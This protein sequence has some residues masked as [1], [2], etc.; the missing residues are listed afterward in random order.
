MQSAGGTVHAAG[1]FEEDIGGGLAA[2]DVVGGDDV[3]EQGRGGPVTRRL[4][5][6]LARRPFEATAMGTRP[7]HARAQ[8]ATSCDLFEEV[9]AGVEVLVVGAVDGGAVEVA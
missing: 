9:K 6:T 2:G 7:C 8:P 1:G 3:V 4:A 5:V